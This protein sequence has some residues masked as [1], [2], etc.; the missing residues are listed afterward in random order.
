M[1]KTM[2]VTTLVLLGF[3]VG[4]SGAPVTDA[5]SSAGGSPPGPEYSLG[6]GGSGGYNPCGRTYK[7]TF[8]LPDGGQVT[9]EVPVYCTIWEGDFGDPP[10]DELGQ[11]VSIDD[12][13]LPP[14]IGRG[15]ER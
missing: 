7:L 6:G 4:C 1:V 14:Q 10:P 5:E 2:K 13:V 8:P 9:K 3:L 11:R 15:F 12:R